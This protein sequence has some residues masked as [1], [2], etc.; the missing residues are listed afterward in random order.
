MGD[1]QKIENAPLT[2][3]S[4]EIAELCEKRHGHVLRDIENMLNQL[5][6]T[7]IQIWVDL[8]DAYGRPQKAALLPKDLTL[9]LIAGYNV[10]LRKR[11]IDRWQELEEQVKQTVL[12]PANLSRMQL[13]QIAMEAEQERLRLAQENRQ[14]EN[15]VQEQQPKVE[16][17]ERIA[18]ADGSLNM[19][20]AA[21]NLNI[22]PKD[23]FDFAIQ[24]KWIYR[25]PGARGYT[26]YQDKIQ[27]G[28]LTHKI[29]TIKQDD[30][31]ERI[32]EQ[33]IVTPKG[34]AKLSLMIPEAVRQ[35]EIH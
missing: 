25:R 26:A 10:K 23:F 31:S 12:N 6:E 32:N 20:N 16:G 34:L 8:P 30:G 28:Y 18:T 1:I 4:R 5:E 22:R 3:S 11:I 7:S 2:M 9:T 14:L 13:I 19:T 21:K 24:N 29:Y 17:F 35:A 15:K 27:A 33:V